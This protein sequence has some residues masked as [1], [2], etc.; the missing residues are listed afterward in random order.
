MQTLAAKD[1]SAHFME[2]LFQVQNGEQ[3]AISSGEDNHPVAMLIPYPNELVSKRTLGVLAG[4]MN[5]QFPGDFEM[6]VE[7]LLGEKV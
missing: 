2:I 1:V 6:S 7:E 5:V 4:K 3:V